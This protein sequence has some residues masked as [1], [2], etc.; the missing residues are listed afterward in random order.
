MQN[1]HV[2]QLQGTGDDEYAWENAGVFVD[3]DEAVK[4]LAEINGE[5]D[6]DVDEALFT[7]G[8]TARIEVHELI[9]SNW[10]Y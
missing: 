3:Y 5:Y 1:V 10:G 7:L 9:D 4:K 2:L 8:D 6:K